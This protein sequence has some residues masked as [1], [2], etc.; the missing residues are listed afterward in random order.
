MASLHSVAQ[1]GTDEYNR[2]LVQDKLAEGEDF[3]DYLDRMSTANF[4]VEYDL[5]TKKA[6]RIIPVVFHVIHAYGESNISKEQIEDQIRVLNED[7]SRLNADT[8]NTR[9]QFKGRAAS[10]DIEFRL[11]RIA[12]DGSCTEGI[13]RKYDPINTI[14][15]YED[16]DNEAKTS[17]AAWPRD[18]YLN[19]WV[20]T[21]IQSS[22]TTGTILGYA[23][24]PGQGASTDGIVCRHDRIGTIGTASVGDKGRTMTHEVGHWLGLYHPFQGGCNGQGDRVADTPPVKEPSYGC[25]TNNNSCSNDSPNELDMVE[26]F[27]DYANGGC[28]NMFTTGQK[29]RVEAYLSSDRASVISSATLS[30]TGVNTNSNCGPIAD[31]WTSNGNLVICEG[32]SIQFVDLSYNGEV[33]QRTWTFTGG[34]PSVST[35][36]KPYVTYN[37]PGVY[38]VEFEVANDLGTNTLKRTALITVL[39]STAIVSAPYG[40]DFSSASNIVSWQLETKDGFGWQRNTSRGFSGRECLQA[41]INSNTAPNARFSLLLPPLDITKHGSPVY[42]NYRYAY[43]RRSA[44]ASEVLLFYASKDCGKTWQTIRG[45]NANNGLETGTIGTGWQPSSAN[46]WGFNQVDLSAYANV[47]NLFLRIDAVSQS[48][49]SIFLDDINVGQFS[50]STPTYLND[51]ELSLMPNPAQNDLQVLLD[52]KYATYTVSIADIAGRLLLQRNLSQGNS[53]ISTADL[54]NGVYTVW[55]NAENKMWSKKLIINK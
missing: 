7:Y 38:E 8:T 49:N 45:Y 9:S 54:P 16:N 37:E 28:M 25:P 39:P 43:A 55:V 21:E 19:V 6:T 30:A 29:N 11:A 18:R 5:K 46:D 50:L 17:V 32:D 42:L 41:N 15:D 33:K 34:S 4:N 26:N 23:Q 47:P 10:F 1:C 2:R 22:S 35:F 52:A 51:P 53:Q 20:V 14:E 13:T 48:G 12:P 36:E 24:F 27:M 44:A 3:A 40:E 31:F